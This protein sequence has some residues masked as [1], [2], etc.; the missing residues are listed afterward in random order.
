[1]TIGFTNITAAAQNVSCTLVDAHAGVMNPTYFPKTI[2]VPPSGSPVTLLIWT[3][4]ENNNTAFTY[5]AAS[6]N[7]PP[8]LGVQVT[9]QT[10]DE[11]VGQ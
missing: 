10:Y 2:S 9:N 1:M 11:D 3:G 6:C 7:L 8:G 5:P 4:A